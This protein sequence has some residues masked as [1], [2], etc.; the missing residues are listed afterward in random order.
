MTMKKIY[1]LLA[2]LVVMAG[3]DDGDMTFK[4][5][6][7]EDYSAPARC[8][9][10]SN[11]I[12][13]TN[14]SEALILNLPAT[15]FLNVASPKDAAGNYVPTAIAVG[16]GSSYTMYYRNYSG[17][18]GNAT[19]CLSSG[20]PALLEQ[21]T[22]NGRLLITTTE[23][24]DATTN[25]LTGYSHQIVIE[26]ATLSKG[27]QEV[28]IVN[29]LLGSFTT[30]V[31]IDFD[32]DVL[33]DNV[34]PLVPRRCSNG[35]QYKINDGLRSET[36]EL[37]IPDTYFTDGQSKSIDLANNVND[38]ISLYFNV[39]ETTVDA[40]VVC[41]TDTNNIPNREQV[42]LVRSGFIEITY[43]DPEPGNYTIRF[44]NLVL[45]NNNSQSETFTPLDN[46]ASGTAG[47]YWFGPYAP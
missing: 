29:N 6:N 15:V 27:D 3:C 31:S 10:D 7:F 4:A 19:L 43:N 36:L 17:T 5:L 22:A 18:V 11:T 21:W 34:T 32:F 39:Y 28:T 41:A 26:S 37:Q 8:G 46:D 23:N 42:W 16:G 40:S 1:I 45:Y 20:T 33:L 9:T 14:G 12:Y 25:K 30:T 2:A 24:R 38:D 47:L 13:L 35:K 44:R